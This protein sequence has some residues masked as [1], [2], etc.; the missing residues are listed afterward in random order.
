MMTLAQMDTCKTVDQQFSEDDQQV[1]DTE[2]DWLT[3]SSKT[4]HCCDQCGKRFKKI[5]SLQ[6]WEMWKELQAIKIFAT[7]SAHSHKRRNIVEESPVCVWF[8]WSSSTLT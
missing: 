3:N 5:E 8:S 6:L 4:M 2:L 7:S 1:R